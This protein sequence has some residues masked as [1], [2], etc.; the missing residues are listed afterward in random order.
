MKKEFIHFPN[1]LSKERCEALITKYK[2]LPM[3]KALI[4]GKVD[5]PTSGKL[6]TGK[7]SVIPKEDLGVIDL[8]QNKG[9][10]EPEITADG[11]HDKSI[12]S[13]TV[14]W[15]HNTPEHAPIF[16]IVWKYALYANQHYFGFHIDDLPSLQFTEYDAAENGKYDRHQDTFWLRPDGKH[17]KM[18]MV[19]QLTD[20]DTYEGGDF[21][22]YG[23]TEKPSKWAFKGQGTIIFFPSLM[24]HAALP[25]TKGVRNSLVGWFEGPSWR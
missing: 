2:S 12:R 1:V 11:V 6:Q 13:S 9:I 24:D 22:L 17:R 14:N 25:V 23:T 20:P 5:D 19:I 16:D 8:G 7:A 3:Q 21:E 4:G 10:E 15:I 18:S